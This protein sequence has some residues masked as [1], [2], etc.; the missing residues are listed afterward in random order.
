M[1][2]GWRIVYDRYALVCVGPLGGLNED[3]RYICCWFGGRDVG[4]L[5]RLGG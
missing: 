1:G 5:C 4:V 3:G 2:E